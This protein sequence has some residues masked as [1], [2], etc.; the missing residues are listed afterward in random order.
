DRPV[1]I[2]NWEATYFDFDEDKLVSIAKK[3]FDVGI[4]LFVL[5]DGWFGNREND[6]AG[7]GDWYVNPKRLPEGISSLSEKIRSFGM[8]F[9]LW[10]EPEMVNKD[11]ELYR[12]H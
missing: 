11:S 7:L 9:G 3:A 4:E 6:C 5:D 12:K 8:K 2:N 10:F 1:L